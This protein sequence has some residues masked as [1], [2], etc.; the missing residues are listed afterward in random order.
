MTLLLP[1]VQPIRALHGRRA[2]RSTSRPQSC[3]TR[4]NPSRPAGR[5]PYCGKWEARSAKT[6]DTRV[7]RGGQVRHDHQLVTI[8]F[9]AVGNARGDLHEA[10]VIFTKE[11]LLQ[12]AFGG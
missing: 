5:R 10:V 12:S 6:V 11:N 4:L 3:S 8:R 2:T 1:V 9:I 7:R